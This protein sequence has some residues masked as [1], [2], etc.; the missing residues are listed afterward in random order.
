MFQELLHELREICGIKRLLPKSCR[1]STDSIQDSRLLYIPGCVYEGTPD[2]PTIHIKRVRISLKGD[3]QKVKEVCSRCHGSPCSGA[4]I[5]Q[6]F[7]PGGRGVET[8]GTFK[9]RAP[10]RCDYR[11]PPAR[12]E[13][14]VRRGPDGIHR[15][16]TSCEQIESRAWVR[17][18]HVVRYT[19][20][21]A[22]YLTLPKASTTSTPAM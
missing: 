1:L 6:D 16:P 9:H 17:L 8:L 7:T 21:L 12:F 3:S 15:E 19:H 14:D 20:P 11:S 10:S 22:S 2:G 4:D 5:S 18:Y 13:L